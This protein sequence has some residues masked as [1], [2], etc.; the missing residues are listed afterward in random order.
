MLGGFSTADKAQVNE[1]IMIDFAGFERY[2]PDPVGVIGKL[3]PLRILGCKCK[4]C[5]DESGNL[6]EWMNNFGKMDGREQDEN[7]NYSLLPARALGYCLGTKVWAQFHIGRIKDIETPNSD[8]ILKRLIFPEESEG[9]KEDLK[10]LIEQHGSITTPLIADPIAGKGSG[11]TILLHG[12]KRLFFDAIT[13]AQV[14]RRSSRRRQDSHSRNPRKIC[15]KTA[16]RGRPGRYRHI[17]NNGR[18]EID[19][20]I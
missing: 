18:S 2:A 4:L 9:V 1:S 5:F 7:R 11:L 13:E 8:D 12:K 6:S 17:S 15:R 10:T 3:H 19:T 20:H 16:L 14:S